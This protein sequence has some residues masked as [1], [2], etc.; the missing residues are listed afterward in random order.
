MSAWF[1]RNR[2]LYPADWPVI[3]RAVK[4][5]AGW[6]CVRCDH[7]HDPK[8]GRTLGPMAVGPIKFD[9]TGAAK[10]QEVRES[11]GLS[12]SLQPEV[13]V[14]DDMCDRQGFAEFA[15]VNSAML[16]ALPGSVSRLISL[17]PPVR[18][19]VR[20][21]ATLPMRAA[22]GAE[23]LAEPRKTARVTTES[24]S[25][26]AGRNAAGLAADLALVSHA[27]RLASLG[28]I[29]TVVG[30]RTLS[31]KSLSAPGTDHGG[32]LPP[33]GISAGSR[34][35]LP[36]GNPRGL[37]TELATA[38]HAALYGHRVLARLGAEA[39]TRS[40]AGRCAECGA[41]SPTLQ[42]NHC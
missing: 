24:L 8:A 34:T 14:R 29:G 31:L 11:V 17:L 41:A 23:V 42:F 6:R 33:S 4:E 32:P 25:R 36:E 16:A 9:V 1:D 26:A 3:A 19:V 13:S 38:A 2:H 39:T 40:I 27:I 5:A 21:F 12:V 18:A 30:V 28:A 10:R 35:E 22:L 7:P 37:S 15:A 20:Q